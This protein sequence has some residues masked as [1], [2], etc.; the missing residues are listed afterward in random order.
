MGLLSDG[1]EVL[2]QDGLKEFT[3]RGIGLAY[4]KSLRELLPS[5]GYYRDNDVKVRE[6]AILDWVFYTP[7]SNNP[8]QEGGII[9]S[10]TA[11]TRPEDSV[12]IVGGGN[13]VTAVR[14]ARITGKNGKIEIYEGGEESI[15]EIKNTLEVNDINS[16]HEVHYAV[17]GK[18]RDVYGGDSTNANRIEPNELPECDV[19]ELDCEGSEIDILE[20]LSI[21][22]RVVIVELHPY[23]FDTY[24]EKPVKILSEYGYEVALKF[25]HDG[26]PLLKDEYQ[27]LLQNRYEWGEKILESGAQA[28]VVIAAVSKRC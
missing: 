4:R 22:P 21:R 3:R 26:I 13:G 1:K 2:I 5:V 12:V 7:Y 8:T 28:P 11:L 6:K 10:H 16:S 24:P 9:S 17:V 19:L 27:T 18:E 20:D 14:A 23:N 25:G 15:N